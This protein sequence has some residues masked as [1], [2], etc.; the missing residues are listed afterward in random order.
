MLACPVEDER[1]ERFSDAD[2]AGVRLDEDVVQPH[3]AATT[4]L[5]H[6]RVRVAEGHVRVEAECHQHVVIGEPGFVDGRPRIE[7]LEHLSP[8]LGQPVPL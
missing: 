3:D 1:Q 5:D 4:D 6:R 8:T 7:S 2:T